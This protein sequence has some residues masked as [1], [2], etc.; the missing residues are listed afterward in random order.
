MKEVKKRT[1]PLHY[2]PG[3]ELFQIVVKLSD[4]PG[5][6][7]SILELLSSKVN[8]I[9][10]TTY[11]LSDGTAMFSGFAESIVKGQGPKDLEKLIDASKAAM[12]VVVAS[13]KDGLLVDTFHTGIVVDDEDY[14][15]FRRD[16]LTHMFDHVAKTLGSGGEALLYQEGYTLSQRNAE[17]MFNLLGSGAGQSSGWGAEKATLG[18][19]VGGPQFQ[20]QRKGRFLLRRSKGLLRMLRGGQV[21]DRVQLHAG[22]SDWGS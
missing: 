4:E 8:L 15:L 10:T 2:A 5:S 1:F 21:Q 13:G 14:M 11:S 17:D 9:G 22:L 12:E 20:D 16:G 19:G 18:P 7:S 3:K 6:Y